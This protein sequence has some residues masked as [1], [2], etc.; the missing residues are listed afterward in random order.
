MVSRI[1]IIIPTFNRPAKLERALRSCL[2]QSICPLEILVVDNGENPQTKPTVE[3]A[4]EKTDQYPIQYITSKKFDIRQA[5][6]K[7]IE[8][9]KGDW[10]ILLDDDDFLLLDRIE[11]DSRLIEDAAP[12]TILLLQD[13]LRVDYTNQ[14]MW[15][16]RMGHKE[17]GI[18]QALTLD[19]FPPPPAA[20]WRSEIAKAHNSYHEANG[21]TDFD[22]YA[23]LLPYGKIL[24]TDSIGYVMDDTRVAARLTTSASH[25][26]EMVEQHRV[27]FQK[28]RHLSKMSNEA[29]DKRLDQQQAFF[30]AKELGLSIFFDATYAS[31]SRQNPKETFKGILAP[32]RKQFSKLFGKLLPEMRGSK[33]YTVEQYGEL[34]PSLSQYVKDSMIAEQ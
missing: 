22:L 10:L 30:A 13:F 8:S 1:S 5:L 19:S 4:A 26:L 24:K 16:H 34:N 31:Y 27:R 2:Q 12:D 23:S 29:I 20:T 18:D 14:L 11:K 17:M 32:W 15:E 25:M 6:A 7:G 33:T 28:H 21:G 3:T 9:A